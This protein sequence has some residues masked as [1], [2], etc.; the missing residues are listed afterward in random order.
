MLSAAELQRLLVHET[1]GVR[2]AGCVYLARFRERE[3]Y[4]QLVSDHLT[5]WANT[6]N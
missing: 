2:R 4:R 6:T 1:T 5:W 3:E